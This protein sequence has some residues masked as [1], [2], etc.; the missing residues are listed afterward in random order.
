MKNTPH[1]PELAPFDLAAFV[2]QFP[3]FARAPNGIANLRALILQLAIQGKLTEQNA[4][5]N[6]KTTLN[7]IK[8]CSIYIL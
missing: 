5:E 4:D 8:N 3:L 6:A 1:S 7:T 2:A